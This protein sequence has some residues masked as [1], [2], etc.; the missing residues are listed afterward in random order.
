MLN[1]HKVWKIWGNQFAPSYQSFDLISYG[2]SK[3]KCW[4]GEVFYYTTWHLTKSHLN[5]TNDNIYIHFWFWKDHL[6]E[7]SIN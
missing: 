2:L 4:N 1:K 7:Q 3:F 6:L 5:D